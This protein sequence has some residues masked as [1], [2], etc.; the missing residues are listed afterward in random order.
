[1]SDNNDLDND[2]EVENF[3]DGGFDDYSKK[4]TLGD[5][6]RN[7]PMVKVGVIL[8]AFAI[9]VG[10]IILFGGRTAPPPISQV[11]SA[12]DINETPGT[13]E[14]SQTMREAIEEK[15]I[16]RVEDAA[17]TGGSAI[18]IPVDPAKGALP[19]PLEEANGEDPLERWRRMQE[20]RIRQQEMLAQA[21]PPE[22]QQAPA[23]DTKTPAVN[24]LSQSMMS[25]MQAILQ[26]QTV[27]ATQHKKITDV[28]FMEEVERK[29]AERYARQQQQQQLLSGNGRYNSD[30]VENILLPAGTIE[31]GQILIEANTDA[32]GPILA[33][34][35]TGPLK[36][37]RVLGS[38][39]STD[40]YITLSFSMIIIDGIN[41]PVQAVAIDP[42]TTLPGI[43]T[44]IDRRYFKRIV[45]PMAAEFVSGLADAVSES[46]TTSI[47]I[48]GNTVAQ[49]TANKSQREEV[50][51]GVSEAGEALSDILDE[52]ADRTRPMLRVASGTPVGILFVSP[53]TDTNLASVR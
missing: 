29:R 22:V 3:D 30:Q 50:A 36:G 53:V 46:G 17:R 45:L 18:P 9:V 26:N 34:I 49:S 23:V 24:A 7:N 16:Q 11:N 42:D 35:F 21:K 10:G 41:Y 5:L 52:E 39:Q 2:L 8:A 48:D 51:S 27:P 1:M 37:A 12:K 47:Y 20:E 43:V 44:E 14:V 38:F 19:V 6:W 13:S 15:N 40:E 31:Y 25:Q 28:N 4:G 32:P 33:Q